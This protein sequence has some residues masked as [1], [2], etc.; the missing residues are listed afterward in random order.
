MDVSGASTLASL[1]VTNNATVGGTFGA[2]ASTL[3]SA[4]VTGTL[5]VIGAATLSSATLSSTLGVTGI[6]SMDGGIQVNTNKFTVDPNGNMV[7]AG[8]ASIDGALVVKGDMITRSEKEVNVGDSHIYL[9]AENTDTT[10]SSRGGIVINHKAISATKTVQSTDGTD[11]KIVV[12]DASPFDTGYIIQVHGATADDINGLYVV[13]SVDAPN[14]AIIIDTASGLDFVKNSITT[15]TAS[16][17]TISIVHVEVG[18]LRLDEGTIEFASGS[19][20]DKF[21]NDDYYDFKAE[22]ANVSTT[23]SNTTVNSHSGL[24]IITDGV[25]TIQHL[26][27]R[28]VR[29]DSAIDNQVYLPTSAS[30]T[31]GTGDGE[32]YG[33]H[34]VYNNTAADITL[35]TDPTS[36]TSTYVD[37]DGE[38][39][40]DAYQFGADSTTKSV[41]IAP[42]ESI[43]VQYVG[44]TKWAIM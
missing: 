17:E 26:E 21:G 9:N 19:Q 28:I 7:L 10:N 15:G 11:R 44:G 34:R 42:G 29:V 20:D 6:S 30:A 13:D 41:L 31:G 37:P 40:D 35:W 33:T 8:S 25:G 39:W 5:G 12:D 22:I 24:Q 36:A 1:A 23:V 27:K 16:G 32:W 2:G 14:N 3:A 4:N 18:H 38:T 43:Q